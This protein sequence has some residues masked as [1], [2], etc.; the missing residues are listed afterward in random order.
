MASLNRVLAWS[1]GQNTVTRN[2]SVGLN[3]PYGLFVA[4]NG[5][6]Y[7]DNGAVNNRVDKWTSNATSS[8]AVMNVTSRCISLFVDVNDS[9]YCSN[10]LENKVVK[11]SLNSASSTVALAAGNGTVGSGPYMLFWPNGIYVDLQFNLYVA[12]FNNNRIQFFQ[13]NQLNATTIA[14]NGAP[15]TITLRGPLDIVLDADGYLF[16]V[17]FGNNR[18]VGSGPNGFRCVAGCMGTY[19]SASNELNFP[20]SIS[21]DSYGNLFIADQNNNRIQKFLLTTNSCGKY[22]ISYSWV[23]LFEKLVEK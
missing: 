9:L 15:G 1:E 23:N 8:I 21:F 5:D 4:S 6:I 22:F 14:G 20:V 16:I 19:G 10:D 2:I 12:D 13:P 17:D 11:V 18:V 3:D 7:V